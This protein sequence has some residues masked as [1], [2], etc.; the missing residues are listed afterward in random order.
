MLPS[1][2]Q[3]AVQDACMLTNPQQAGWEDLLG[4]CREAW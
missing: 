1:I 4:I 3:M 2:C